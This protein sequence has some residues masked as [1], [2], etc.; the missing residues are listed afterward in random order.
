MGY[1]PTLPSTDGLGS[2]LLHAAV[3]RGCHMGRK[4]LIRPGH[5][6]P[7]P[8]PPLKQFYTL[9]SKNTVAKRNI[10]LFGISHPFE[11][12]HFPIGFKD[13]CLPKRQEPRFEWKI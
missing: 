7:R 10:S 5:Y 3:P 12:W 9:F 6:T 8:I 4:T 13:G 1:T 2:P 11:N